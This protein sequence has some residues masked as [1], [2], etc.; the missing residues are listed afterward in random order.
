LT[1][2]IAID[3]GLQFPVRE[4]GG[5]NVGNGTVVDILL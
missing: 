3:K 4:V 1:T 2:P 5:D